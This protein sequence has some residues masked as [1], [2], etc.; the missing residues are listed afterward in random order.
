[1]K[2]TVDGIEQMAPMRALIRR[3]PATAKRAA[4]SAINRV[5]RSVSVESAKHISE[6]YNLPAAYVSDQIRVQEARGENPI[7][8]VS[9]RRRAVR[10]ARF[11]A[12][13]LTRAAERAKGDTRRGIAAGRAQ[14]GV[15]VNVRRGAARATLRHAFMLPLRAGKEAGGNGMGIFTRNGDVLRHRYGPSPHK[16]FAWWVQENAE[17]I[18]NRLARTW[19][20]E[21]KSLIR[22]GTRA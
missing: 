20:A 13:Q 5:A 3:V 11:G 16:V 19:A 17:D 22:K 21:T 2:L 14:A 12:Q 7:A 18:R 10:L 15:S 6:R 8:V 1:M 4:A 9:A